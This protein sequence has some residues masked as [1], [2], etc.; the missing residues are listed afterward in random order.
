MNEEGQIIVNKA[1][2]VCKGYTQI[3]GIEFVETF[4]LIAILYAIRMF[5]VFAYSKVFKIY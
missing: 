3:D 2:L 5:L 4:T 1:R